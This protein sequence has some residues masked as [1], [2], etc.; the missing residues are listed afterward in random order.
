MRYLPTNATQA[1]D[2]QLL[3]LEFDAQIG[4]TIPFLPEKNNFTDLM[5][6]SLEEFIMVPT[7]NFFL[8]NKILELNV[9]L[10]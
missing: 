3:V 4:G 1:N 7:D 9:G 6:N 5:P 10:S 2:P 8:G